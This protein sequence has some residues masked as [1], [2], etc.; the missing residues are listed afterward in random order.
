MLG[1]EVTKRA[2]RLSQR[3]GT[4]LSGEPARRAV[5]LLTAPTAVAGAIGLGLFWYVATL[6][7]GPGLPW[8]AFPVFLAINFI[9]LRLARLYAP[10][11]LLIDADRVETSRRD[12]AH[13]DD[14]R[15]F[16]ERIA[17]DLNWKTPPE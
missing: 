11:R 5:W 1:Y 2:R 13:V 4:V 14:Q 12:K 17:R 3:F 9:G 8:L 16:S 6:G 7:F 10:A 15:A